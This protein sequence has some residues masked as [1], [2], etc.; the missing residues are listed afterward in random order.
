MAIQDHEDRVISTDILIIGGGLSGL[1]AAITAKETDS[2]IEVLV[3]DKL[4]ASTGWAGMGSRTAGLLS[5]VTK[6][7]DPEDFIKYSLENIGLYLNDQNM[8]RE[9]AYGTQMLPERLAQWGVEIPRGEDGKIAYAKWP[10]P[11]GTA[12]IDPDM[13]H[14]LA[15]KAKE[16]GVRFLDRVVISELLADGEQIAGA[17][18]FGLEDGSYQVFE[19]RAVVVA[20]GSQN[21]DIVEMWCGTG[22]GIR[23]A[24]LAGAEMRNAEF[25]NMCDFAR[26]DPRG[27]LYYGVHGWAHIAHDHL[28][29]AKGENISEKYRPGLH[30]S[31]DPIAA[32]AWYKETMAGNGPISVDISKFSGKEFF[33]FHPKSTEQYKRAW[34]KSNYPE[35]HKFEVVPGFIG[36]MS[37]VKVDLQMETTV[38]GLF[39]IG[40]SAGSGSS[41]GGAVPTPPSKVHGMGI[42]NAVFMGS[43]GGP[44]ATVHAKALKRAG[45]R[46]R[47]DQDEVRALK[48]KLF[49]PLH[50]AAGITP[51]EFIPKVQDAVGP[52]DYSVIKTESRMNEALTKVLDAQKDLPQL[53]ATDLHELARCLDA[54]S[55]AL[56]AEMFYRASMARTESRGF[57]LRE[58]YPDRDDANWLKWIIVRKAGDEMML[59]T[60]DIPIGSYPYKPE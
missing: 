60:D 45:S 36:E 25:G 7:D 34:L 46:P 3:V 39:A 17:V 55:M 26:V 49:A 58:D 35:S 44:A 41:R 30:T 24:Y 1:T 59:R 48:E 38:S 8:L 40:N 23:A 31:M 53:K 19:A 12:S 9:Y 52:V 10:F 27:W 5:F 20:M 22:N 13:C 15:K 56:E 57:H 28:Q 47:V 42:M 16:L 6:E 54:E 50:R 2:S 14:T 4:A 43:K 33:R 29:N 37:C 32:L 18:G 11:F 21:Y 51:K